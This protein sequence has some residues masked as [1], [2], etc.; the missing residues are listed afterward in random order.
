MTVQM[1]LA[2][3]GMDKKNWNKYDHL[4]CKHTLCVCSVD[5]DEVS[6]EEVEMRPVDLALPLST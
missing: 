1:Y 5:P 6:I 4:H 3:K 2:I